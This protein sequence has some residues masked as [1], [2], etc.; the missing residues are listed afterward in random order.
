MSV[1]QDVVYAT[2]ADAELR[3]DVLRPAAG[4]ARTAVLLLHGGGWREGARRDMHRLGRALADRGFLA[5]P[6]QYRLTAQAPWPAAIQD[7]QAAICW[8]RANA[9]QLEIEPDRIAL[10]GAGAGGHLALLAAGT[11]D[12]PEFQPRGGGASAEANA[13]VAIHAPT[14][15]YMPGERP[16]HASSAG[17]LMGKAATLKRARA[18]SPTSYVSAAFPP[19]LFLHGGADEVVKPAASQW[20]YEALCA[21]GAAAD[22]HI[23]HGQGHGF[24]ESPEMARFVEAEIALFIER[25]LLAGASAADAELPAISSAA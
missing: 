3:L 21:A 4:V 1:D 13:V 8:T 15:L 19:T 24:T 22:L 5:L 25:S 11:H 12:R 23:F 16:A 18:A 6:V 20:M 7:V 17:A 14:T 2:A 10:C 9:D